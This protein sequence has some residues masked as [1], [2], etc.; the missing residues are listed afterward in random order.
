MKTIKG[1][2]KSINIDEKSE[3]EQ[4]HN[5]EEDLSPH[6]IWTCPNCDE[7][8]IEWDDILQRK[9]KITSCEECEKI[10]NIVW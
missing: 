3:K 4:I 6:V 8:N 5:K 2:L 1:E 7:L 9:N 10:Y